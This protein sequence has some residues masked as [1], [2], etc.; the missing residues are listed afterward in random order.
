M[1]RTG[2][3]EKVAIFIDGSNLYNY[4]KDKEINFPKGAIFDLK[5]FS[6]FLVGDRICVSK[7]YYTGI[8]RDIDKSDK[9]KE[10]VRGQQKFLSKL[11]NDGFT[12]KRGRIIYDS[13]KIREKGVDV[14]IATDL[15]VGAIDNQFDTAIIITSDTDLIPAI[16]Y[17]RYKKKKIEYV[18]FSHAPSFGMQKHSDFSRLLL[19]EDVEKFKRKR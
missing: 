8:F 18:G 10:L 16:Q 7:R 14:K 2:K 17:I 9:S 13:G 3:K 11:K 6:K 19:P 1:K 12:I 4:L 15:I 5:A